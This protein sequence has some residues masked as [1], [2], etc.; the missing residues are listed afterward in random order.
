ML[1]QN[2]RAF[3]LFFISIASFLV[4]TIDI[5]ASQVDDIMAKGNKFYRDGSYEKAIDEYGQ[6]VNEGY[7]GTSLFY[8]LGNSYYRVGKIGY[9]ILYYE[10][11]LKLSPSDEDVQHNLNFARLSTVDRIQPLPKFFLFDW[12]ESLLNSFSEN[13]WAY[14][15]FVV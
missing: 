15:V 2:N 13:G 10:K 3:T 11:A 12:W 8:N 4:F 6:L 9:A 1:M 7:F 5:P 14:I